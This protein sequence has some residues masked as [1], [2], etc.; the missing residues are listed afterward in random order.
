MLL[1][2]HWY[3]TSPT[4]LQDH[5]ST[6]NGCCSGA[7]F[8]TGGF[9]GIST[10]SPRGGGVFSDDE[11]SG[12]DPV[13][14]SLDYPD[15]QT[16]GNEN[17]RGVPVIATGVYGPSNGTLSLDGCLVASVSSSVGASAKGVMVGT[18]NNELERYFLGDIGEILV[19]P[20]ALSATEVAETEAYLAAAWPAVTLKTPSKCRKPAGE[21]LTVS[22]M[23]AVT[24]YTQAVQSR[25]VSR[26][27]LVPVGCR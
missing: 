1:V 4:A 12:G 8:F 23:Y 3:P 6:G 25:G 15:S 22:S 17:I 14:A 11:P 21:G 27:R 2:C 20:R 18:R 26:R 24:R 13:I 10:A 19:Y 16:Y 7:L 9:V 5:G